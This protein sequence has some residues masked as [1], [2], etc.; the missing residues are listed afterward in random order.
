MALPHYPPPKQGLYDPRYEHDACGVGFVVDLK[1]RPSHTIVRQAIQI[2]ENL[3][4][5][6]ACG[7]E[8]N[9]GDGAGILIQ[10]PHQFLKEKCAKRKVDLPGPG[11][12][13]V[14]MLFTPTHP[15]DQHKCERVIVDVIKEE[16]QQFL[17]WRT[18][19]TDNRNLGPS[20]RALEPK[21]RQIFIQRGP[22]LA[23]DMAFERKLYVIRKRIES[24]IRN[25]N[26]IG[27]AAC[28]TSPAC[29]TRRS[30]T[31]ACSTP[32]RCWII[33]RT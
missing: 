19:P 8:T 15:D 28:S 20:A 4:H 11:Q 2:L 21:M 32:S 25:D 24:T 6:G 17:G 23:D 12:Y 9:T 30:F 13:G 10:M 33:F 27:Q 1:G 16:G 3:E 22:G 18:V 29:R 14:G 5:R 26:Q 7:C 31:R